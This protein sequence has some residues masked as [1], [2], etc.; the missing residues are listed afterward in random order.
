[1]A[2]DL[3]DFKQLSDCAYLVNNANQFYEALQRAVSEDSPGKRQLRMTESHKYS[4]EERGAK[5][6]KIIEDAL[7]KKQNKRG[8]VTL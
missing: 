4:W 1:V 6:N 8:N 3:P 7:L 2:T 5:V